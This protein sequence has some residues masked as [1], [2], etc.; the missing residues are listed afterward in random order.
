[1][2][3]YTDDEI[4]NDIKTR[5]TVP[6]WPHYGWANHLSRGKAYQVAN[7][8]GSDEFLHISGGKRKTIRA[9]TAPLRRKLGIDGGGR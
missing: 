7:T 3:K 5:P 4:L 8:G 9:I 1:M 6:V 2:T